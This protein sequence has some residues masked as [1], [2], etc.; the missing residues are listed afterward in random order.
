[1]LE[2]DRV[3][4]RQRRAVK[5]N[6]F[7]DNRSPSEGQCAGLPLRRPPVW[8]CQVHLE[9]MAME[10]IDDLVNLGREPRCGFRIP[11]L[12]VRIGGLEV[13]LG[14]PRPANRFATAHLGTIA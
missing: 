10:P 1:M 2:E 5:R 3:A 8:K 14:Q 7:I 12:D 13:Q 11:F 9:E 4:A 6:G